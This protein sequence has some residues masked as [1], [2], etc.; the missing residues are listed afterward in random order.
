MA[1]RKTR[2]ANNMSFDSNSLQ[3]FCQE[4]NLPSQVLKEAE[5]LCSAYLHNM[6]IQQPLYLYISSTLVAATTLKKFPLNFCQN[7]LKTLS[8][9]EDFFEFFNNFLRQTST[10]APEALVVISNYA[11][12]WRLY[13]KFVEKWA[14][15]E[16]EEKQGHSGVGTQLRDMAW[17]I[18]ALKRLSTNSNDLVENAHLILSVLYIILQNLPE[19]V[20]FA[21]NDAFD[22]LIKQFNAES[23]QAQEAICSV[24]G[25]I[26]GMISAGLLRISSEKTIFDGIFS[27]YLAANMLKLADFYISSLSPLDISEIEFLKKAQPRTPVKHT[28]QRKNNVELK[29]KR[30]ISWDNEPETDIKS[31]LGD[32]PV[33][34][35]PYSHAFT[36]ISSAMELN[37]WLREVYKKTSLSQIPILLQEYDSLANF[38]VYAKIEAYRNKLASI[39]LDK[40]NLPSIIQETSTGKD[41]S[42]H[43]LKLYVY[44]LHGMIKN[45]QKRQGNLSTLYSN[46]NFH[47]AT[48]ACC[49]E[50]IIN[51][52]G[53]N[54]NFD[55]VLSIADVSV[56][57]FW[58]LIT[59]F[60]Q[61]DGKMPVALRKHFRDV[62]NFIMN[63]NAWSMQSPIRQMLVQ[64]VTECKNSSGNPIFNIFFKRLLSHTAQKLVEITEQLEILEEVK[65]RIWELIKTCIT[66][67]S[68][69]LA[70]RCLDTI[71]LCSIYAI[72][73]L[74]KP[75]S[76]KILIENFSALY[77]AK[78]H[79][80]KQVAG[81]GDIIKFYNHIFIPR[82]KDNLSQGTENMKN[83]FQSPLRASLP[84]TSPSRGSA[85]CSPKT[86]YL[87]PR[88]RKLWASS[89]GSQIIP[90]KKGRLISFDDEP[91]LPKIEE[92]SP[93]H[94]NKK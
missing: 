45:E 7:L 81:A 16:L 67:H 54:I 91:V 8:N 72:C 82:F 24:E 66:E 35:S 19:T 89:E 49:I 40:E 65:E 61:F 79:V 77:P 26:Q 20:S 37:N 18:I 76:F 75:I 62:E 46:E 71:I 12:A 92:V 93:V 69:L 11:F 17:T 31:K 94:R 58:K 9:I 42:E 27:E 70:S 2:F 85:F 73:K 25:F 1:S 64:F 63:E 48:F 32:I 44:T 80:F 28:R 41:K 59:T 50:C 22:F 34:S 87:T 38:S 60:V 47:Q 86:P 57:E 3:S 52:Y 68:D 88:T 10:D 30:I 74:F 21:N 90:Q 78:E 83:F 51:A 84:I 36:P 43:I 56:F 39:Q 13:K 55:Q 6:P 4:L 33:Q 15:L 14:Q 29:S 53:L 23:E 5:R